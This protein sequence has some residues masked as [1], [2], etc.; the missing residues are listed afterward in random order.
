MIG[1]NIREVLAEKHISSKELANKLGI[2]PT[3]MS[4]L[5]NGKRR[6]SFELLDAMC[7]VLGVPMSRLTAE[8]SPEVSGVRETLAAYRID[9]YDKP[10]TEDEVAAV[11]A[12]LETYRKMKKDKKE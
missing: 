12:Y 4:Y 1:E 10:L 5:L 8:G 2:S 7:E 9:G 6:P 11:E 3:H